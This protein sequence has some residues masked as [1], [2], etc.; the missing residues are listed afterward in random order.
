MLLLE[1]LGLALTS[2]LLT[3]SQ[4]GLC[5]GQAAAFFNRDTDA[6]ISKPEMGHSPKMMGSFL[7]RFKQVLPLFPHSLSPFILIPVSEPKLFPPL[8]E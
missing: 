5:S 7:S 4:E 6:R 1:K 3:F 8:Q 2:R